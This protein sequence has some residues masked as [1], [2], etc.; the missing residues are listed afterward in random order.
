M[1]SQQHSNQDATIGTGR[2]TINYIQALHHLFRN[3]TAGRGNLILDP[4][5]SSLTVQAPSTSIS[6]S[7]NSYLRCCPSPTPTPSS[8][9]PH[10][11]PHSGPKQHHPGSPSSIL[12][13]DCSN[14]HPATCCC[15]L[16]PRLICPL[17]VAQTPTPNFAFHFAPHSHNTTSTQ[18]QLSSHSTAHRPNTQDSGAVREE[19]MN[20]DMFNC[21]YYH[22]FRNT[23]SL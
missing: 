14:A 22:S 3:F 9:C 18:P 11:T 16:S 21:F 12:S 15:I 1:V 20:R 2:F 8:R 6:T 23:W 17:R 7:F 10:V 19:I 4:F 13:P 5:M